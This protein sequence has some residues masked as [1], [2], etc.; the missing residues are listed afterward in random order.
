ME[1]STYQATIFELVGVAV[2]TLL[3]GADI[4][5]PGFLLATSPQRWFLRVGEEGSRCMR[6][7]TY[8]L[9]TRVLLLD[10]R[11]EGVSCNL[12]SNCDS[13]RV[14]SR[15]DVVVGGWEEVCDY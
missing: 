9:L 13:G 2:T 1:Q 5:L 3:V 12:L 8:D 15:D 6:G 14:S 4:R 7:S 10:D 11:D